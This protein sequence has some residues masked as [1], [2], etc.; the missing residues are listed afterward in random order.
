[1][2]PEALSCEAQKKSME[3]L[4]VARTRSLEAQVEDCWSVEVV[5]EIIKAAAMEVV[6]KA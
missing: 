3:E 1:M 5:E 2:S 6:D 4:D